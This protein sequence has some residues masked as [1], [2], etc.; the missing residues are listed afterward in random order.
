MHLGICTLKLTP[1]EFWRLSPAELNLM[2][3]Q[4]DICTS[5]DR[6]GFAALEKRFP[7]IEPGSRE[8]R[9]ND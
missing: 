1:D 4:S 2:L 8:G 3:G 9:K 5:L 6:S 7:D